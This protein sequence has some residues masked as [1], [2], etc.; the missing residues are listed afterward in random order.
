MGRYATL[1]NGEARLSG[2]L[3]AV[4]CEVIGQERGTDGIVTLTLAEV[5]PVLDTGRKWIGNGQAVARLGSV[6]LV[7]CQAWGHFAMFV[8]ALAGFAWWLAENGRDKDAT[9]TFA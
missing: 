2:I 8:N 9:I 3:A 7:G 1:P 4:V 5:W 6:G